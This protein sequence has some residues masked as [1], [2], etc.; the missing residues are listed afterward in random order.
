MFSKKYKNVHQKLIKIFSSHN[1]LFIQYI[2]C[3]RSVGE[4]VYVYTQSVYLTFSVTYNSHNRS[5]LRWSWVTPFCLS[6]VVFRFILPKTFWA[7]IDPSAR[8]I[9]WLFFL[10]WCV[11]NVRPLYSVIQNNTFTYI[12]QHESY[13]FLVRLRNEW[14]NMY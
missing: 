4:K 2:H 10:S 11:L 13:I 3:C 7:R 1:N 9:I 14:T 6:T 5:S 8:I 12:T